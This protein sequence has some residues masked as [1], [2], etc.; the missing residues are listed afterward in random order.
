MLIQTKNQGLKTNNQ[1]IKTWLER[2]SSFNFNALKGRGK[3]NSAGFFG[4]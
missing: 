1:E 2:V 4:F 3:I